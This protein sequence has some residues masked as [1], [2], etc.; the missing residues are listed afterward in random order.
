MKKI[1]GIGLTLVVLV[2][3]LFGCAKNN[4]DA[5]IK[6]Y[7]RDTTS[8]TRDGF[9]TGIGLEKAKDDNSLLKVS[10]LG[11]VE[12]NGDMINAIKNDKYGIGYISMASLDNRVI[13]GLYFEG[14]EPTEENVLNGSY[15]LTRNFNY[16]T[17]TE[18][19]SENKKQIVEAFI[20]YLS[21]QEAKA[22]MKSEGGIIDVKKTDPSWD[23]IKSNYLIASK[24]NSNIVLNFGGSTSVSKMATA[25]ANEFSNLCGN[26]GF[27]HN[28]YGSGD[29]Y[30]KTQ[31]A[32]KDS[33]GYFDIAFASR[34]FKVSSS[35]PAQEGT[36]NTL[37]IDAI[38]VVVNKENNISSIT[39]DELVDMYTGK[40]N[41]WN[42]I[43]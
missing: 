35:E 38:V 25:L 24:D 41:K 32:D 12:S 3:G 18:Y 1:L 21:T 34:D 39:K 7:T 19:A 16:I 33:V 37:C 13:K 10:N 40:V 8:G 11:T 14:I 5:D 6:L 31:G 29:A 15:L 26:V 36:Y 20:G 17:R 28:Y 27:T 2:F 22:I 30:K 42:E 23:D 4:T 9:F 43:K